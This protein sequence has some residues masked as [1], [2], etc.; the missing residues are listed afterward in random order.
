MQNKSSVLLSPAQGSCT[1]LSSRGTRSAG[2]PSSSGVPLDPCSHVTPGHSAS[3]PSAVLTRHQYPTEAGSGLW[4]DDSAY[5]VHTPFWSSHSADTISTSDGAAVDRYS[6]SC[7]L[8]DCVGAHA[9]VAAT[10]SAAATM[11]SFFMREVYRANVSYTCLAKDA[12]RTTQR[13]QSWSAHSHSAGFCTQGCKLTR[14]PHQQ[15][16]SCFK[17]LIPL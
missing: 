12:S 3:N 13:N 9:E 5:T 7:S 8:E 1:E 2:S 11:S 16:T 15:H 6:T 14:D 17:S 10:V 4:N